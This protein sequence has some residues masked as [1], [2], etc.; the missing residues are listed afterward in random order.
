MRV[1]SLPILAGTSVLKSYKIMTWNKKGKRKMNRTLGFTYP[2]MMGQSWELYKHY[3]PLTSLI[4]LSSTLNRRM[5]TTSWIGK[6]IPGTVSKLKFLWRI[7]YLF[8]N[9][10]GSFCFLLGHLLHFNRLSELLAKGQMCLEDRNHNTQQWQF[11][12]ALL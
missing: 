11:T 3:D 9:K 8:H 10:S 4:H 5:F 6:E 1:F 2:T 12:A 7:T